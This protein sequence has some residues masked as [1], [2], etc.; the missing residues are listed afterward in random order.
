MAVHEKS[1]HALRVYLLLLGELDQV[2]FR[3]VKQQWIAN[4]L[5]IKVPNV[6]RALHRLLRINAIQKGPRRGK[7]LTYRLIAVPQPRSVEKAS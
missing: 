3:P 2:D 5:G 4:V 7:T 1:Q 6:H